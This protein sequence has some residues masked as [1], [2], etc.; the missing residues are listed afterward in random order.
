MLVDV[1]A[2]D[3][4][5]NSAGVGT[6]VAGVIETGPCAP[7]PPLFP[8]PDNAVEAP[9]DGRESCRGCAVPA[10]REH[11]P[12]ES[13]LLMLHAD[14]DVPSQDRGRW[15]FCEPPTDG[16]WTM[17]GK[18]GSALNFRPSSS[19]ATCL[20]SSPSLTCHADGEPVGCCPC[21]ICRRGKTPKN[22]RDERLWQDQR[23]TGRMHAGCR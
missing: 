4:P 20:R 5:A 22:A 23:R 17:V 1:V 3:A 19:L 21:Q 18:A 9:A 7:H 11:V 15:G 14:R 8:D 12:S 16:R 2:R 10:G 6:H 13:R